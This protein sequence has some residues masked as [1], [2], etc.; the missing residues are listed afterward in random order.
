MS[1][2]KAEVKSLAKEGYEPMLKESKY[3]FLKREENLTEKQKTKLNDLLQYDLKTVRAHLLK[4][5]FQAF[6]EY[7]SP[8]L[9]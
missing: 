2:R 5:S 8:Y 6:W 7:N 3:C 4:E 9:G 1:V